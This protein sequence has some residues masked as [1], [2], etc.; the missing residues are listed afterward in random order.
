MKF[1]R[2]TLQEIREKL[3]MVELVNSYTRLERKGNRWW[4]LSPFKPEKTASFSVKPE[5]GFY[6]CFATNQG[7][8]IFRFISE[9]EGLTFP[10]AVE[11]LAERAGVTVESGGG[12][13]PED[14]ERKA[15]LELY[16]RVSG[17]FHYLLTT[18]PRGASALEYARNRGITD[19]SIETFRLGYAPDN[20]RWLFQFLRKKAYS[21]EFLNR[22]GLFS[23]KGNGYTLFRNRLMFPI[24]DERERIVAF[25]GRALS[26]Q[27]RA[28]YINSPETVIYGKKRTLYGLDNALPELRKTRRAYIGE[29]YLDVIAMHQSELR[30]TV[31]PLGTAFT[32]EQA[33]LLKRW[34]D[35]VVLV[36]DADSA[37]LNASFK[38]AIVAERAGL[39]CFAV[40]VPAGKDPDDLYREHGA[41]SVQE[42][43]SEPQPVFDF[44]MEAL[45]ERL[46]TDEGAN[47]ELLL[48]RVFPYIS[49][50]NSEVRREGAIDALSDL[51]GVSARAVQADFERWR[52]GE[53]PQR[54]EQKSAD[55][56]HH[57]LGRD[58]A[59]MLATAQDGGLFA[60]LRSR[61]S[62]DQLQDR[63]ARE[64][65]LLMED[66][67]R[68]DEPLPRGL[69][70]RLT[71]ESVRNSVLE[72]LTS[73]EF[74]GW[75]RQD[76]DRAVRLIRIRAL[77]S[78]AHQVETDL[79]RLSASDG[80][81]QRE[82]LEKKMAIDQELGN[83]K[84]RADD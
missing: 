36:F 63:L 30:N 79:R 18:D 14:Q 22:S 57:T 40:R 71:E 55:Q 12:P 34:V 81:T 62:S 84:V 38:A 83:L 78:E 77:E 19:E 26:E 13:S 16:E 28:K 2:E 9:M 35:E 29:G 1:S 17:S 51:L 73:G 44:M 21:A 3:D 33:K 45:S 23:S 10:E 75:K 27:D 64:L 43:V 37:G 8:D 74:T 5:D 32:D 41:A 31:A 42:M 76:V 46:D 25:G 80:R 15:L 48:Q 6:Y 20:G 69:I 67:Y 4:G 39:G 52:K 82:L 24:G 66:A 56:H 68:H 7:G 59:L 70:D 65:F 53:Q 49:I 50:I 58:V 47:R 54:V 72:R 61:L 11:Y 60:Y